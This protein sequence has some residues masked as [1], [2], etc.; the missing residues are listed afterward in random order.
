MKC[1]E[2]LSTLKELQ[3]LSTIS[4]KLLEL[5]LGMNALEEEPKNR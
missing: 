2:V 1:Q 4:R 5:L 3:Q